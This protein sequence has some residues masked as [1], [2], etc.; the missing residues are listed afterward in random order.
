MSMG[1][2]LKAERAVALATR[3]LAVEILCACQAIDLLAP[4]VTSPRLQQ[5][6]ARVRSAVK[7]LAGDRP[8]SPDIERIAVMIVDGSLESSCARE[9]K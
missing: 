1:A 7:P 2:A 4:L 6:H 9:V 3:V 8:P 5:V